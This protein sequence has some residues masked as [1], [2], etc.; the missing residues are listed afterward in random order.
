MS[1]LYEAA[2]QTDPT[3][4]H[5]FASDRAQQ[6]M[7]S[8]HTLKCSKRTLT[9]DVPLASDQGAIWHFEAYQVPHS[10]TRTRAKAA[11]GYHFTSELNESM[12]LASQAATRESA[13]KQPDGQ[14]YSSMETQ[15]ET[16]ASSGIARNQA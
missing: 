3:Y 4:H 9:V 12:A 16:H 10:L 11:I 1:L 13:L 5:Q 8:I 2:R 14:A 15:L 7:L 6:A